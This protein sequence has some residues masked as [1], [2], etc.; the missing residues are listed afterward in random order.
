M[1]C[2]SRQGEN[3][4]C[5]PDG[6]PGDECRLE[7]LGPFFARVATAAVSLDPAM[8]VYGGCALRNF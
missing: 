3:D 7:G 6:Q 2:S 4:H 5:N 8:A 1:A